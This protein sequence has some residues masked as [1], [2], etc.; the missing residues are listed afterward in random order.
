MFVSSRLWVLKIQLI[1][2]IT[3]LSVERHQGDLK[4]SKY[5][6]VWDI[7]VVLFQSPDN[8]IFYA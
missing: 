6:G 4:K 7:E 3:A 5:Q 1:G 8:Q 2:E